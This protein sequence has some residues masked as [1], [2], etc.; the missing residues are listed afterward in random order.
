MEALRNCGAKAACVDVATLCSQIQGGVRS[1]QVYAHD[2]QHGHCARMT[3]TQNQRFSSDAFSLS[4]MSKT[5][6][7]LRPV[8]QRRGAPLHPLILQQ[9]MSVTCI[10]STNR[11]VSL[12]V[13]RQALFGSRKVCTSTFHIQYQHFPTNCPHT[14][15]KSIRWMDFRAEIFLQRTI[16][17]PC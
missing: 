16:R 13:Y 2:C 4:C 8:V 11:E 6:I 5:W 3:H 12:S 17:A 1:I 15:F 14:Q 9:L 7:H 10:D